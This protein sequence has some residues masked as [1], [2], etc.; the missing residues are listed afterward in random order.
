MTCGYPIPYWIGNALSL[1]PRQIGGVTECPA[2][3]VRDPDRA[4]AKG[5]C[6][7]RQVVPPRESAA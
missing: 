2:W 5:A 6:S 3:Q 7:A 1:S 4:E